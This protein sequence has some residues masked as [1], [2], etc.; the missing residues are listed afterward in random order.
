MKIGMSS[1]DLTAAELQ[2]IAETVHS[3]TLSL[4]TKTPAFESAFAQYVNCPFAAAVNSG[5]SA[6]HLAVIAAGLGDG[7]LAITTPFSFVASANCLLYERAVPVFV[8]VDPVTGNLDPSRVED[9]ISRLSRSGDGRRLKAVLPVH[10]FGQPSD[11]DALR[12]AANRQD[13]I[14][15]EDACE[16][17]GAEYHGRRAGS[18]G[19]VAAFAFYPNKQMTTGEGGMLVTAR[20]DW[21]ELFQSLRNQ[22]RD[23]FDAWLTHS[24]LGFNYRLDEMSASLGLVQLSRLDELLAK[25]AQVAD[26]YGKHLAG[27]EDLIEQPTIVPSTTRMSWFVYVVR[28][29][30]TISRGDLM[31]ELEQRGVPTRPYFTPIHLQSFYQKRFGFKQGD[32]PIAEDLG[33]RSLALPFSSVMTEEQVSEVCRCVLECVT[34]G[35]PVISK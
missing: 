16:A 17:V 18:L 34:S 6:L 20:R 28:L 24:R 1:P 31:T 11:M 15:I 13:L 10:T 27:T 9:T 12:S 14:L 4:G 33:R 25:R 22:G 26:W 21:L 23:I 7:D 2:S 19:D 35:A 3:G 29:A 30:A 5:T 32:F 8:D